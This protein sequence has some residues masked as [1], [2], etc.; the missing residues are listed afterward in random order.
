MLKEYNC[1]PNKIWVDKGSELY[2][3]SMKSW[4]EDIEMYATH[5]EEKSDRFIG[6]LNN[7]IYKYMTSI[8]KNV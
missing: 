1:K 4:L 6:A 8:S 7:K 3:R 5:N 2:N